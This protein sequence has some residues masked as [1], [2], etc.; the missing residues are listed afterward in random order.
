[1]A[2]AIGYGELS[3]INNVFT[4]AW[5][6]LSEAGEVGMSGD[7]GLCYGKRWAGKRS[8]KWLAG[9]SPEQCRDSP[10]QQHPSSLEFT[11]RFEKKSCENLC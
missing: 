7:P 8:S 10:P 6:L 2:G 11:H 5:K 9:M 4:L 1:M 3:W